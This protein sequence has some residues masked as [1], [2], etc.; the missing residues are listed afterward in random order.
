MPTESLT[1]VI[2]ILVA[3]GLFAAALA[4]ADFRTRSLHKVH[5]GR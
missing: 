3:F 1:V 2:A 4:W 5:K